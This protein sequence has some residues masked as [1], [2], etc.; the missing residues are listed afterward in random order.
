MNT[1]N[2]NNLDL[3]SSTDSTEFIPSNLEE[4]KEN[5]AKLNE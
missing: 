4:I 1:L 3:E 2:E 5:C